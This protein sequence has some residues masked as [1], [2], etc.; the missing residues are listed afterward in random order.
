[1]SQS[2][3]I[4]HFKD[5]GKM[6]EKYKTQLYELKNIDIFSIQQCNLKGCSGANVGY[7]RNKKTSRKLLMQLLKLL[8]QFDQQEEQKLFPDIRRYMI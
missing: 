3:E 1:M 7:C 5:A 6:K 2:F 4:K 8:M